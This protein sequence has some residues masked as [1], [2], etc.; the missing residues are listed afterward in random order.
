MPGIAVPTA[1]DLRGAVMQ[2]NELPGL[3]TTSVPAKG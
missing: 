3:D 1:P 2:N